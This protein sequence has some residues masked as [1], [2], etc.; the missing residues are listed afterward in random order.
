MPRLN[1]GTLLEN[2]VVLEVTRVLT[3]APETTVEFACAFAMPPL[4][5]CWHKTV[6]EA[7]NNPR[8]NAEVMANLLKGALQVGVPTSYSSLLL[9]CLRNPSNL[10]VV[11]YAVPDAERLFEFGGPHGALLAA[12]LARQN[13][14]TLR[15]WSNDLADHR[16]RYR[17]APTPNAA[18][19]CPRTSA[20]ADAFS[21]DNVWA[22]RTDAFC[23][24]SFRTA[25]RRWLHGVGNVRC[26]LVSWIPTAT[27]PRVYLDLVR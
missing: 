14:Q 20:Y 6:H 1:H 24:W 12:M 11:P 25:F 27:L 19:E 8:F 13:G 9:D 21:A 7:G 17:G 23:T 2:L 5:Q 15:I 4:T 22:R 3:T 16:T 26:E 10:P 18:T